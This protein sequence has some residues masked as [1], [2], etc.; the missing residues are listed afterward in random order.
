[1][2]TLTP[3]TAVLSRI[4]YRPYREEL[5][6][7]LRLQLQHIRSHRSTIP[8]QPKAATVWRAPLN[9]AN[10]NARTFIEGQGSVYICHTTNNQTN[11]VKL[12]PVCYIYACLWP[13]IAFYWY[14]MQ[15]GI[16]YDIR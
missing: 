12:A 11:L 14:T 7:L 4:L 9:T 16:Y 13:E 1:M 8:L 6:V 5:V 10:K 3:Y 2:Y 15:A